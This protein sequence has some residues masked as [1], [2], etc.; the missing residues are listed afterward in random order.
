MLPLNYEWVACECEQIRHVPGWSPGCVHVRFIHVYIHVKWFWPVIVCELQNTQMCHEGLTSLFL[1]HLL[2]FVSWQRA[3]SKTFMQA[4]AFSFPQH[5]PSLS[6]LKMTKIRCHKLTWTLWVTWW[7]AKFKFGHCQVHVCIYPKVICKDAAPL[8]STAVIESHQFKATW[9]LNFNHFHLDYIDEYFFFL[10][11]IMRNTMDAE[12][13]GPWLCYLL[14]AD[15]WLK[16]WTGFV[17][18]E[19]S[20]N[21]LSTNCWFKL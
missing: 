7:Q 2:F 13:S 19:F 10:I 18:C 21:N 11:W 6:P 5:R 16:D 20:I 9:S 14:P 17:F 8:C 1:S 15:T 3:G 12:R 4:H